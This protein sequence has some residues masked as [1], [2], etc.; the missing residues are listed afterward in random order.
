[1]TN[2]AKL[3][4]HLLT[5]VG[6]RI[7]AWVDGANSAVM[8]KLELA[9]RPDIIPVHIDMGA[10]VDSDNHRFIDD[11]AVW[12]GKP[13]T[14]IRSDK[15]ANVD[16][17][18]EKRKFLGGQHGAPCTGEMKVAPRLDFQLP[19][20]THLW[21]YTADGRDVK[22]WANMRENYPLLKQE[23]PLID[24]GVTKAGCH[25]I[26]ANA[27]IQP[28]RVYALGFP[29][30]NCIGCSKSSSP[31]YWSAVRLHFPEVWARRVDQDQR[32]GRNK[33]E[34]AGERVCLDQLPA[35]FPPRPSDQPRCD[36][37]C[38]IAEQDIAA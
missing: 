29:N 25:A 22:R 2:E 19:S 18:F 27:G 3:A 30:A 17:V 38:Q 24:R 28:P 23:A 35:D 14:R 31:G 26:L 10:S 12:F 32:F 15:F 20:D 21:G 6:G 9:R 7:I 34:L 36:F 11:L 5:T 4:D 1:M 13:I 8:T 37:L 16:E 33:L